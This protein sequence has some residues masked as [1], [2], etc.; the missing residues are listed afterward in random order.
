MER[1]KIAKKGIETFYSIDYVFAGAEN[2]ILF[3]LSGV[4]GDKKKKWKK[5]VQ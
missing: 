1:E 3:H 4:G 2:R 5:E